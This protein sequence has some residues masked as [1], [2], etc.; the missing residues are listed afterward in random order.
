MEDT[1]IL[2]QAEVQH[3]PWG[4][5]YRPRVT[6]EL[7]YLEEIGFHVKMRCYE[8]KV[9]A[10]NTEPDSAVYEDSCM[11]CFLNFYPE[12]SDLY[13]NFEVNGNGVML[14]QT[15]SGK[16]NRTFLLKQGIKQ[17][18]VHVKRTEDWWEIEYV[19]PLSLING[20]YGIC[21]FQKG[22]Q[23]KG[24]FYK[25]GDRTDCAHYG[26]WNPIEASKPNFHLPEFFGTLCL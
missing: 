13:I 3:Y 12:T 8:T 18:P 17:P 7:R 23:L 22:H 11:E 26:C 6:A 1:N 15:G 16:K 14:C 19:I 2:I 20:V 9:R 4:G 25:C 10:V 21:Q 24:N 5:D